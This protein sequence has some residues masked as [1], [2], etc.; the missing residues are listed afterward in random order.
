MTLLT[1][2]GGAALLTAHDRAHSGAGCSFDMV[3]R[4]DCSR[5]RAK[6]IDLSELAQDFWVS[7]NKQSVT[8]NGIAA[9]RSKVTS[10]RFHLLD[11]T[12][13]AAGIRFDLTT[14]E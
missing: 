6:M 14:C 10:A 9:R 11:A 5:R 12:L 7:G 8:I 3:V 13:T 4:G 2:E 1:E